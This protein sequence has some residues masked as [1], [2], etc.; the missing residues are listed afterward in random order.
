MTE[1]DSKKVFVVHG[2][3][4]KLRTELFTFLRALG[5]HPVEWSAAVRATGKGSPYI[6]DVL[7]TAFDMAQAVV[8]LL[9]PDDVVYLDESL[10]GDHDGA[11]TTPQGQARPN[12]LFEAGMAMGRDEDRTVLVEMGPQK[13]FSDIGGRHTLR[14]DNSA[15]RRAELASRLETAGC[16]VDRTGTDWLDAGDLTPPP[17][18]GHGLPMGKR[19]ASKPAPT[20]PRL[21]ARFAR[22]R[23]DFSN[24]F[25]RNLGPGE[26]RNLTIEVLDEGIDR[27]CRP[28]IELPVE[29]VPEGNEAPVLRFMHVLASPSTSRFEVKMTATTE[30]GQTIEQTAFIGSESD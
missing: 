1:R 2:R 14:L 13:S 7:T 6:G 18:I 5:L 19:V 17:A 3:N 4:G 15:Q 9:T 29:R 26:V 24:I 25:V 27:F 10:A 16:D 22:G 8:V 23:G 21:R 20:E 28:A 11:E 30:T 12:V